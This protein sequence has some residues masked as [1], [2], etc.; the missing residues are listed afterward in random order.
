MLE[1]RQR[2]DPSSDPRG[3]VESS[4]PLRNLL[5]LTLVI[6]AAHDIAACRIQCK[7]WYA[8]IFISSPR[9]PPLEASL[10]LAICIFI[11]EARGDSLS[12]IRSFGR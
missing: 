11:R 10:F 6:W 1:D 5:V 8:T 9:R 7:A 2:L 4:A 12:R 3:G